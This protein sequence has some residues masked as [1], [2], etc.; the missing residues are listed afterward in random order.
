MR[1]AAMIVTATRQTATDLREMR[2]A[3]KSIVKAGIIA[4]FVRATNFP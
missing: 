3:H 4:S 2:L 1:M